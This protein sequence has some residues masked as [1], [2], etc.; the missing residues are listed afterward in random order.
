[1]WNHKGDKLLWLSM[2]P[3]F[4]KTLWIALF[5]L[6][7]VP[8][9]PFFQH[10]QNIFPFHSPVVNLK[11]REKK[12]DWIILKKNIVYSSWHIKYFLLPYSECW[13]NLEIDCYHKIKFRSFFS[14]KPGSVLNH[15]CNLLLGYWTIQSFK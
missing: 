7:T 2:L 14:Q 4:P 10:M 3:R 6:K 1:M 9:C 13:I 8:H 15:I 12:K 5:I 11:I